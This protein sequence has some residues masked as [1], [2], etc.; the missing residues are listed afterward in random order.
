MIVSFNIKLIGLDQKHAGLARQASPFLRCFWSCLIKL[1]SKDTHM[2]AT[3]GIL[4]ELNFE[5]LDN[6][7]ATDRVVAD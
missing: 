4:Y 3:H 6:I 5:L 1:V 7:P 2:V